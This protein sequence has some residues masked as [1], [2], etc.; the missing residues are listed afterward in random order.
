MENQQ[1]N[2]SDPELL[3]PIDI[4]DNPESDNLP[5]QAPQ[6]AVPQKSKLPLIITLV[7]AVLLLSAGAMA[8]YFLIVN[9]TNSTSPNNKASTSQSKAKNVTAQTLIN[10]I[11][12]KLTGNILIATET[13]NSGSG[14]TDDNTYVYGEASIQVE[15][16]KYKNFPKTGFGI[17]TSTDKAAA[18]ANLD[19]IKGILEKANLS[20]ADSTAMLTDEDNN[21]NLV[22]ATFSSSKIICLLSVDKFKSY[23]ISIGCADRS[24]YVDAAKEIEPFYAAYMA[25]SVPKDAA[26]NL[27]FGLPEIKAGVDGYKNA[28]IYQGAFVGLYYMEP[29]K[30]WTYFI[31]TQSELE[32]AQY[33]T[34]ALRKS[35]S[36]ETCYNDDGESKVAVE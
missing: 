10:K 24:S 26:D 12:P 6:P 32:C 33:N 3:D 34:D 4:R 11:K 13:T 15:G 23:Q 9:K 21:S 20:T 16:R 14:L 17:A 19:I 7:I 8:Y 18:T 36:G 28:N 35:F 30:N 25:T 5:P 1:Q 29:G 2:D 31:G 22:Y 27:V